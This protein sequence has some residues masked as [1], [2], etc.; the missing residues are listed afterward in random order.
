[1]PKWN[2]FQEYNDVSIKVNLLPE[3]IAKRK[4]NITKFIAKTYHILQNT[5]R[6]HIKK[7][8]SNIILIMYTEH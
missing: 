4:L 7:R 2:L 5:E 1:M 8:C 6:Y 3:T